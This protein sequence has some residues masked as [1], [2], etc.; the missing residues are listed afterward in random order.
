MFLNRADNV[1]LK[2]HID[3]KGSETK[4]HRYKVTKKERYKVVNH[5]LGTLSLWYFVT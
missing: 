1:V 5:H 2:F 4:L 3:A